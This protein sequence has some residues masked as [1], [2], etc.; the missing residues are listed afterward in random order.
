MASL[1][2]IVVITVVLAML[3]WPSTSDNFLGPVLSPIF[4][5]VCK[6]DVCG[7]G[8]CKASNGSF[9]Y[10]CECD[11][12]W[13]QTR[14]QN[15]TLFKFLPCII[16]N[17]S[18]DFNCGEEAPAPAPNRAV[19]SSIFEPCH[20]ADCGGGTCNKTSPLTFT[21]ECKEG[22][23]NLL[24]TTA[25]PCFKECALGMDCKDLGIGFPKGSN[26]A[27]A[28]SLSDNSKVCKEVGCGK[29]TC[30]AS[31]S[32]ALGYDCECDPGWKQARSESDTSLKFLP[33]VIPNCSLHY[34]C[35]EEAPAPAP[36]KTANTSIFEPCH[37][38]DCGGG[39]CR[40]ISALT[41]DC[42]CKTG[43]FNLLNVTIF[44]CL[45]ECALGMD[46]TNLDIGRSTNKSASPPAPSLSDHT[47]KAAS[48]IVVGGFVWKAIAAA[49]SVAMFLSN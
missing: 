32:N 22:Y 43:Y 10:E 5:T 9:G 23:Y 7:K 11:A 31:G 8:T 34:S 26:R 44:P 12:G 16:P 27:P 6:A 49:A 20:Y 35:G 48:S 2:T 45:K 13:K 33:C 15:D 24:N 41:Y 18:L 25:F 38:A 28:P 47:N 39:S 46:C 40:K 4:D 21:C 19:N 30:K 29:G 36:A 42:E 14:S 17:C 37:W 3:P 1:H